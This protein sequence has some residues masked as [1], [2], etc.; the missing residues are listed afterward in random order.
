MNANDMKCV[1][2]LPCTFSMYLSGESAKLIQNDDDSLVMTLNC[3]WR[4]DSDGSIWTVQV[5]VCFFALRII[6]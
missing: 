5:F 3:W 6:V 1:S 2:F 4:G